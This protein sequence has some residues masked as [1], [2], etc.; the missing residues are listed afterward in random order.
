MS[1]VATANELRCGYTAVLAP[2]LHN[3]RTLAVL[4]GGQCARVVSGTFT[5]GS[6]TSP[7][8]TDSGIFLCASIGGQPDIRGPVIIADIHNES[9][10]QGNI[11]H[12]VV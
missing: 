1:F 10:K 3:L 6:L 5:A 11:K 4:S 12:A 7:S 2:T 9:G 8:K